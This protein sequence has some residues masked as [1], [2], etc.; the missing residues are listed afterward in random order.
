MVDPGAPR[1]PWLVAEDLKTEVIPAELATIL[2]THSQTICM[3]RAALTPEKRSGRGIHSFLAQL[4]SGVDPVPVLERVTVVRVNPGGRVNIMH[5]LFSVRVE[6]YLTQR[7]LFTCLGNLPTEV[8]PPVV[9]IPEKAFVAQRS[10]P[11]W[12]YL[13]ARLADEFI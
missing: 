8:L 2:V 4:T 5:L 3:D 13:P 12:S 1:P 11:P 10:D 7:L 6:L 9:E